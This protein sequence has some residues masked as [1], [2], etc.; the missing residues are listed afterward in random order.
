M[1]YPI[2]VHKEPGSAYG[3]IFPDFPGC[4]SAADHI[5]DIAA[6]A[7]EAV[8]AHFLNDADSI[9]RPSSPEHWAANANYE[10]GFWMMVDIDVDG[11]SHASLGQNNAASSNC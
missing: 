9:P 3:I 6:N 8:E 2:Y 5:R 1:L 4:F 11:A 10:N 7:Q